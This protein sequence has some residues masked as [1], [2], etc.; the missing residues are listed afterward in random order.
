MADPVLP[1]SG[2]GP[3]LIIVIAVR[4]GGDA[5]GAVRRAGWTGVV[6]GISLVFAFGGGIYGIQKTTVANA[7]FLFAAAPFF[8]AILGKLLLKEGVRSGTKWA[9]LAA[10]AGIAV[11]VSEGI[12]MGHLAGNAAALV[13]ALGFA[14]FTVALRWR[15]LKRPCLLC[16]WLGSLPWVQQLW[17]Y[18]PQALGS[19]CP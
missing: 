17:S 15:R 1:L 16:S 13:S 12:S 3:F 19:S 18:S 5:V 4:A 10:T 2:V 14:M 8:A 6:G 11:M 9:M 7:M